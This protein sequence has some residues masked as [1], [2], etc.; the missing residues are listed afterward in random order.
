MN[1]VNSRQEKYIDNLSR[2]I[3]METISCYEELQIEKYLKFQNLLKEL[4]PNIFAVCELNEFDG[5]FLLKWNGKNE[6]LNPI[7]FMNHQDVVSADG[8]W[9]HD[10]FGGEVID[11]KLWGRGTLDDKGGLWAMLQAADEL[12]AEGYVPQ[13][14]IYFESSNT[15]ET[16]GYGADTI[17]KWMEEQGIVLDMVLDEGGAVMYDPIGGA[18]GTFAAV[19]VGEKGCAEIKFIAR[20]DGGHA[21]TPGKNTPLVRLG[22]F[23]AY[24]ESHNLFDTEMSPTIC[25]MLRRVGGYMGPVSVALKD[26]KK[27]RHLL[28]KV[29]PR[30]SNTA[31]ALVQTT[32]AFTMAQGSD[33]RNSI[34]TVAWVMGNMRYSHHQGQKNSIAAI[35]KAADK[36]DLEM[37][38]LD[39]GFES[40]LS[41]F[42]GYGFKL[43]EQA[44]KETLPGVDDT[45]P[46]IQTGASD[47]RY[48]DRVCNQCMRFMPFKISDEQLESIHGIN[49]CI[50]IECL[51]PAVDFY[52]YMMQNC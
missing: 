30:L 1:S 51:V 46:Y 20:C 52:R 31:N 38:I 2:M 7:M 29:L 35:K 17:S 8:E 48:F 42:N 11:G 3:R 9:I 14:T 5:S 28:A 10:P 37:E 19:G 27:I 43:I 16:T 25:E 13:R 15:E 50:D 24:V 22:K 6:D 33:A 41:D 44:V 18:R 26:P 45:I 49:E 34:P 39:P 12:A 23:M 40:G 36:F 47:S 4:F 21:S 32:I